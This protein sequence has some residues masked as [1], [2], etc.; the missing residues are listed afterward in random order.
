M[1]DGGVNGL[2]GGCEWLDDSSGVL[3]G[4]VPAGRGAAPAQPKVPAG[5]N[6][7]ENFGKPAPGP[8][9]Q[10]LLTSAHDEDAL[11]V[12]LHE[13]ARLVDAADGTADAVRQAGRSTPASASRP[14]ASTS[15]SRGSSG[16]SRASALRTSSRATSRSGAARGGRSARSP[17]CRW[18]TSCRST[19]SSPGRA[20]IDVAPARAGDA[21]L[22]RS[23][24][25]G[26]PQEQGAA[27]RSRRHAQG[28]VHGAAGGSRQDRVAVRRL[29]LDR[30]GRGPGDR[31]RPRR[32]A[33][34]GRGSRR[35]RGA[36]R[37]SSG[38]CSSRIAT[39]IPD[40][41]CSVPARARSSRSA[42]RST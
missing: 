41:R 32:R 28:A 15:W 1:V 29:Q 27:P 14:T 39:R 2:S 22:G 16:R 34:R 6:I 5:P 24:R 25:Q 10:D 8:T 26:R 13:P 33:R 12:L 38:I 36:S 4:F 19:A 7:Q 23:A 40:R 3:C 9:Y 35:Q 42:T 31:D 37:A 17:T 30:E 11:R 21:R 20:A 18:A